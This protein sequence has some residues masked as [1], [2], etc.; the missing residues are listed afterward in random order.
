VATDTNREEAAEEM[1]KMRVIPSTRYQLVSCLAAALTALGSASLT[2]CGDGPTEPQEK[3]GEADEVR[4]AGAL[5]TYGQD[6]NEAFKITDFIYQARGT[7]NTNLVITPDG[8]LVVDTGLPT[9]AERH[10]ELL[11][12]VDRGP[13]RYIVLTHAHMDHVGGTNVWREPD[14][15]IIAHRELEGVQRYLT[16]LVPFFMRRNRVFYPDS[17]PDLP[18]WITSYVVKQIYPN[19]QPTIIVDDT[20]SFEL[21]GMRVEVIHTPGAEGADSISVWLPDHKILLSGD[22]FGPIFPM[23][24]NLYTLRGE[25]IRFALPYIASLEQVLALAPEI[26]IPSHFEPIIGKERIARDVTRMRDAVR[27]VHDATVKGMNDGKDLYTLMREIQLPPE[28]QLST[29]HG[30]VSWGVRAI[31]EGYAG[32]FHF[33]STTALYPVAPSSVYP[34]IV[35]LAGGTDALGGRAAARIAAGQPV[36]ALQLVE[37]AL[38]SDPENQSA[39]Q[40]RLDALQLLLEQ[41]G[42]KNHHEVLW[43]RHRIA[44]TEELLGR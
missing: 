35:E 28:L 13:I 39:L 14:T 18:L 44:L 5:E 21:G 17:V 1:S 8:N 24:P 34:E 36:E 42:G 22:L 20:Y 7:G 27:Y 26:I 3:S 38:A 29:A 4:T 9:Q 15:E 31:W 19:V 37:I 25:K 41:S 2:A 23:F 16:D 12:R 6:Q 32:W 30:K 10:K 40:A 11:Q 33:D 43:L